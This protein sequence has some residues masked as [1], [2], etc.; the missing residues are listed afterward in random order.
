MLQGDSLESEPRGVHGLVAVVEG[1]PSLQRRLLGFI[2]DLPT[3]KLGAWAASSWG[4]CF[5]DA[6]V[7]DEFVVIL[8]SWFQQ[9]DN[10]VLRVAAQGVLRLKKA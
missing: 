9:T 10:N 6:A 4:T 8:Q 5:T 1:H 2:R 7:G 3:A